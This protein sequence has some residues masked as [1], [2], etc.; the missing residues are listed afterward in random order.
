MSN[1]YIEFNIK[2][3]ESLSNKATYIRSKLKEDLEPWERKEYDEI[4]IDV[5]A[6][7]EWEQDNLEQMF[8]DPWF[9]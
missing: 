1:H 3:L 9:N 7:I 8:A 6:E 5:L 4:L 2:K